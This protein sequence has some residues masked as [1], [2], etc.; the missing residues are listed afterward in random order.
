MN[1]YSWPVQ[2][3]LAQHKTHRRFLAVVVPALLLISPAYAGPPFTTDDAEPTEYGHF[4][5]FLFSSGT[6]AGGETEGTAVGLEVD[7]GVLPQTE[8]AIEI[9]LEFE[10]SADGHTGYGLHNLAFGAK[11]RFVDESDDLPQIAFSPALE[12]PLNGQPG[13][14]AT[15]YSLPIWMQKSFGEWT[16]FGGGGYNINPGPESRDFWSFGAAI[17]RPIVPDFSLGVEVFG[18]TAD[19]DEARTSV[20]VGLGALYD[21]N[22]TWHLVG[23]VSTGVVNRR[24]ANEVS[25]YVGLGWSL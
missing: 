20:S 3:V 17:V 7:Y 6:R 10:P 14:K 4:E 12:L 19:E 2:G 5:A 16:A 23:S 1:K 9:P 22:E 18:Q 13:T 21:F 11:Y 15:K 24:A 25:Y 8:I